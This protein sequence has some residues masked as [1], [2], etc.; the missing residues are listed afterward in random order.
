MDWHDD[1]HAFCPS[2]HLS[3]KFACAE[4]LR[5]LTKQQRRR[6]R[7]PFV[8]VHNI[9]HDPTMLLCTSRQWMS[10]LSSYSWT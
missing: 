6:G 7:R 2:L 3:F 5:A 8:S 10:R 1:A 9:Q 4:Q